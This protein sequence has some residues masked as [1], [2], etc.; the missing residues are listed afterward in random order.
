MASLNLSPEE[1]KQLELVRN[2]TLQLTHSLVSLKTNVFN[3]H[4]LPSRESLQASA[5][6]L[7]QNVKSIQEIANENS[8]LFQRIA[9]HPSTNFPGR[10]HEHLV[11]QLLRKKLEPAVE[12]WV[13]EARET[14]KAAGLDPNKLGTTRPNGGRVGGGYGS[15]DDDDDYGL[16]MDEDP[17]SD[18]FNDQWADI[19]AASDEK[20]GSHL[21]KQVAQAYTVAE[22]QM[23][24]ENVRTGL[25]RT[26]RAEDADS[27]D[28]ED[29]EE[30]E[31]D[32][33]E[34]MAGTERDGADLPLS[35]PGQKI[36]PELVLW[37][38]AR[39]DPFLP[40]NIELEWQ[41]KQREAA[42]K[43]GVGMG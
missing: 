38:A 28:E 21:S 30:D 5:I 34:E 25:K 43:G 27:S 16:G 24:I 18:P 12:G 26:L 2:R 33:D 15:D 14:A 42:K 20:I 41:R 37:L 35:G 31:E 29:D 19:V 7:Q 6:I 17:P 36:E 8:E 13:E 1:L 22:Q 10:T 4:P 23:G 40:P 11:Y 3:T 32:E 39:G 9:V